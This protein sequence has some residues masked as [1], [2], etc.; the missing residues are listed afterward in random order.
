[1]RF[2]ITAQAG[3][4]DTKTDPPTGFDEKLFTAYMQFNEAMHQAGILVA[5][6]GL[7]PAARGAR[8]AASQGRRH[9]VDGPFAESKELVGGFYIIDVK[10]LEE[11]IGWALRAPSGWGSDDVLEI[12]QLT[13]P[14]D[15]P[16]E[17]LKLI[18]SAAPTW[19]ASVWQARE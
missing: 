13:G 16:S 5:S 10:S 4:D 12:R 7:N 1:M 11:A 15:I 9:L 6:E 8:V 18:Q 17:I 3:T 2:I 14:G 19:S